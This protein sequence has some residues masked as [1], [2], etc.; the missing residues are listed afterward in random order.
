MSA[1]ASIS[2]SVI[3]LVATLPAITILSGNSFLTRLTKSRKTSLYPFATSMQI[4]LIPSLVA[5]L[6]CNSS[7]LS[8]V[9]P[10]V[11][12]M[13]PGSIPSPHACAHSRVE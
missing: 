11:T 10:Q 8:S 5:S 4:I 7:K 13:L 3:S 9:E 6:R 1:P 2:A 12:A